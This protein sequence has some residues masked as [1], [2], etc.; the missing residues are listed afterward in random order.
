LDN[1]GK[2]YAGIK[3]WG[4]NGCSQAVLK[5][6]GSDSARRRR[7]REDDCHGAALEAVG[8]VS[9]AGRRKLLSRTVRGRGAR[10]GVDLKGFPIALFRKIEVFAPL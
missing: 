7:Y 4:E 10:K 1:L 3:F 5:A 8:E 6:L 2:V 9:G